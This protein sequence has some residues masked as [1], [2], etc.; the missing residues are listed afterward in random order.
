MHAR[1]PE[2]DGIQAEADSVC[3]VCVSSVSVLKE[4]EYSTL[5]AAADGSHSTPAEL[6]P[7]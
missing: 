7:T 6:F 5:V 1:Q 2:R 3:C 4:S